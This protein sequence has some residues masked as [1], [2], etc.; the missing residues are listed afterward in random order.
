M[1]SEVESGQ[2]FGEYVLQRRLGAGGQGEVFEAR[3]A[4]GMVWALKIGHPV[5]TQEQAALARFA[6]EAQWVN[7]TFGAL[8]R[9][10]G[11]LVGEHYGVHEQRFYVKMRLIDGESLAQRLKR[12]GALVER[13]ATKIARKLAEIVEIAHS[14]HAI[15]RDLKPENVL[16]D[17]GGAIQVVDWGCIHL[18]EAGQL[19]QTGAGPLCTLGYAA[20]EQYELGSSASPA[21]DV[22][23]LGVMLLEMLTGYNPFLDS[24]RSAR[25]TSVDG[26]AGVTRTAAPGGAAGR[27]DR[28]TEPYP[29]AHGRNVR[30][31]GPEAVTRATSATDVMPLEE[32][33]LDHQEGLGQ[34]EH[35]SS[36]NT[37]Q[38][39]T[40]AFVVARQLSLTPEQI[41][42]LVGGASGPLADLLVAMLQPRVEKRLASMA[43]AAHQ[44]SAVE[45]RLTKGEPMAPPASQP[46]FGPRRLAMT[47]LTVL[48]L[49]G[50]AWW[51]A[52]GRA[53][54]QPT[55]TAPASEPVA[56]ESE[57]PVEQVV[58]KSR[59]NLTQGPPA[60]G[61]TAS[62]SDRGTNEFRPTANS[63]SDP[64]RTTARR[65]KP[66][67]AASSRG[68]SAAPIVD[69]PYFDSKG[70]SGGK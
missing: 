14:N 68:G 31:A 11:I 5:H 63:A 45:R 34:G 40:P 19:A 18:V 33:L 42:S 8:P 29:T 36:E 56:S 32:R 48:G 46:V 69:A 37:F 43:E 66:S 52:Q 26:R 15:H 16:L 54:G 6:R 59:V 65:P 61:S 2:Q 9:N 58:E 38:P 60:V 20:P 22:Y 1:S 50:G 27:V 55:A 4:I 10:C 13:E 67:S 47:T 3:D 41:R 28:L 35:F 17:G 25:P 57:L 12:E 62:N 51:L 23:S 70:G 64:G 7:N 39:K 53:G 44:L 24:W 21:T 30:G 49:G